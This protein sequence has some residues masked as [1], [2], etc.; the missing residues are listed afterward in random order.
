MPHQLFAA[1]LQAR[2]F[3]LEL[4]WYFYKEHFNMTGQE[5]LPTKFGLWIETRS[6]TDNN[7]HGNGRETEKTGILFQIKNAVESSDGDTTCHLFSPVDAFVVVGGFT[8]AAFFSAKN[9]SVLV[10][11]LSA[12]LL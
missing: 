2:D 1:S 4:K 6:S 7:L 12:H 10:V 5:L 11:L 3:N 8:F 9:I